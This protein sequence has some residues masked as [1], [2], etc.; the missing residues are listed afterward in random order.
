MPALP[1]LDHSE[2]YREICE[3]CRTVHRR[4]GRAEIAR[5]ES[6]MDA[7]ALWLRWRERDGRVEHWR[8]EQDGTLERV[9][10]PPMNGVGAAASG[11]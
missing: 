1:P 4:M 5:Y 6:G 10:E 2:P 3:L 8:Q 9:S 7:G 11:R